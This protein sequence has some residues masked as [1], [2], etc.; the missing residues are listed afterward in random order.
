M[1]PGRDPDS[2]RPASAAILVQPRGS[3]NKVVGI[4]GDA[5]KIQLTAAPVDGAANRALIVFIAKHLGLARSSIQILGGHHSR[6][7]QISVTGLSPEQVRAALL[8]DTG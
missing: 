6:R 8:G 3:Q 2:P 7:K 1:P 4:H 5:I